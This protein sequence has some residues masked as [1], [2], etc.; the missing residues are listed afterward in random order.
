MRGMIVLIILSLFICSSVAQNT[1]DHV[2]LSSIGAYRSTFEKVKY[3]TSSEIRMGNVVYSEGIQFYSPV[4][5]GP[6]YGSYKDHTAYFNLD[7]TYNR[8]TGQIGIDDKSTIENKVTL[9]LLGDD[10]ELQKITMLASDL[11]VSV[12]LDVSGVR[13]LTLDVVS[14][15]QS[16]RDL[17]LD[18]VN[19]VL[20]KHP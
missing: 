4:S 17:Y 11:P 20:E 18:L 3:N 9:T 5:G 13:R 6:G 19:M 12:D 14:D 7:R 15:D 8:L 16:V 2:Y 1:G 10:K